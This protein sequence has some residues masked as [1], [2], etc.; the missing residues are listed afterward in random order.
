M[1]ELQIRYM[2]YR[3]KFWLEIVLALSRQTLQSHLI[4]GSSLRNY[5]HHT[6]L[7]SWDSVSSQCVRYWQTIRKG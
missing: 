5:T 1:K 6:L 2:L 3:Q 7:D 4:F